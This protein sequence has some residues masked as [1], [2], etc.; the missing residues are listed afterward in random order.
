MVR[1]MAVD[2]AWRVGVAWGLFA[3][4]CGPAFKA[5]E[6][7]PPEPGPVGKMTPAPITAG[8]GRHVVVGEMCPT[9]AGGRPAVVPL[10]MRA[11]SWTDTAADVTATVERGSVPRF[12]VF[13]VDGKMAGAFD[14]LGIAD[15]GLNQTVAT[16]TYA[17][18]SPCTYGLVAKV[19][20]GELATRAEDPKCGAATNSCGLAV[21]EISH[22]DEPPV[23]PAYS[24]AGVCLVGDQLVV[25][26]DGDGRNE[27]FPISG[28]LDGIRGPASEWTASTAT[29]AACNPSF[30]LYDVRLF[31]EPAK[32]KPVD[33][34]A[35]VG[36]DIL[37]VVDLDADGKQ[38]LVVALRFP[39]VRTIV[40]YTA[41][42]TAQRL[43]LAGEAQSFQK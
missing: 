10:L 1:S 32:G 11:V 20:P 15:V 18:A 12:I 14:T 34:K 9:V 4:A 29:P 17:G 33:Q 39:T 16:G 26:I 24:T 2:R 31:P 36:M 27:A 6:G 28:V 22:P 8:T 23:T 7:P 35:M 25:D 3:S 43:E 42:G 40:I 30:Q 37:G 13:G 21:G 41:T 19:K 5:P 38:E